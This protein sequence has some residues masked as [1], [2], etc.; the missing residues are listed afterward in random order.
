M[1]H[2]DY[3]LPDLKA[4][5]AGLG[6]TW[7]ST[8]DDELSWTGGIDENHFEGPDVFI[9]WTYNNSSTWPEFIQNVRNHCNEI[10]DQCTTS[11]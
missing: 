4:F 11:V 2:Q 3:H 10:L 7:P 9:V 1:T 5:I 6:G 8:P